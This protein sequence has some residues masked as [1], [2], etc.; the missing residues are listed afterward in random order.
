MERGRRVL[1]GEQM[2]FRK[3]KWEHR[4]IDGKYNSSM[5]IPVEVISYPD[6]DMC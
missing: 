4:K 6:A 5:T 1:L 3:N 2:A